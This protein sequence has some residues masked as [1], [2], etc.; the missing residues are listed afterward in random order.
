MLKERT[1]KSHL[2]AK[3]N[4]DLKKKKILDNKE[5]GLTFLCLP[6]KTTANAP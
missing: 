3:N 1:C 2:I 4:Y 6:L 5:L